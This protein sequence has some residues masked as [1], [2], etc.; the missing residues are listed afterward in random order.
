MG[1]KIKLI[2]QSG[3]RIQKKPKINE[4]ELGTNGVSLNLSSASFQ[5][6]L[7]Q[8]GTPGG[9]NYQVQ[10]NDGGYFG[11]SNS[12]T[13]NKCK[14]QFLASQNS[15]I[16]GIYTY[17]SS[18]IGGQNNSILTGA[19]SS[20]IIGGDCNTM[21]KSTFSSIIGGANNRMCGQEGGY[22]PNYNIASTIIGGTNNYMY[23][24]WKSGMFSNYAS[25]IYSSFN[26]VMM[27]GANNMMSG[28]SFSSIIGGRNNQLT[29]NSNYSSIVGGC[30]NQ[31][32][33]NSSYSS[34]IG[35]YNNQLTY[36]SSYSSIIGGY[37]NQLTD[38][39]Y[40]S[41]IVGGCNNQLT[42][43]SSFSSI[44]GGFCN[45]LTDNSYFS[46]II[47]G[48]CNQLTDN[49]YFSSIIGGFCNQ[50]TGSSSYSSIVG[51][52]NNQ[53]TCSQRSVIIGG[54]N[55][56]LIGENDIVLVPSLKIANMPTTPGQPGTLYYDPMSGQV[57]ISL[58]PS[59]IRLKNIIEKIGQSKNGVNIYKFTYKSDKSNTVYQGVIAQ[60]LIGTKYEN[61]LHME[62]GF[63][64]VDYSKIGVQ[65]KKI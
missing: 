2:D 24:S 52:S 58:A 64:K 25:E 44:I 33:Y 12:L 11:G 17:K 30:N 51:G 20:S 50:L 6:Y 53:L 21:Y 13:F 59:D 1:S 7:Q 39:S 9:Y 19:T 29:G 57:F 5:G 14:T 47:G 31:L 65:F 36:N 16:S 55:L 8:S 43:N 26:S 45:Q 38:N 61:A 28:V 62:N 37:N 23:K 40:F 56:S 34:I 10:F 15:T 54:Q 27:G 41:S 63:Y 22:F 3:N 48:F 46:S 60:E 35:G 4:T 18:I 42:Y 49:S 32:T